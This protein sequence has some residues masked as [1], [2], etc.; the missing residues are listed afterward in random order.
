MSDLQAGQEKDITSLLPALAGSNLIYGA[1]M[2]D[3]GNSFSSPQ[4][5]LD[6]EIIRMI[7]RSLQGINVDDVNLAV[8]LIDEIG[9]GGHFLAE[10]HTVDNMHQEQVHPE[11]FDRQGRQGWQDAGGKNAFQRGKTRAKEILNEHQVEPLSAEV[12][13]QLQKIV[14][15]AES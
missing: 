7:R 3:S 5:V 10:Q 11:L 2:L 12:Q 4:L 14:A 8:D 9:P 13:D 6:N 15:S 1:G